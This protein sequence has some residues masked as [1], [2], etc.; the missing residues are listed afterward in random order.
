M[1]TASI[2]AKI[3]SAVDRIKSRVLLLK[4]RKEL[5]RADLA[6]SES[7]LSECDLVHRLLTN[8]TAITTIL[9]ASNSQVLALLKS[10]KVDLPGG[11]Y[12]LPLTVTPRMTC[13]SSEMVRD[14]A[15]EFGV[16][17]RKLLTGSISS[18]PD[19]ISLGATIHFDNTRFPGSMTWMLRYCPYVIV[20]NRDVWITCNMV[21]A[22]AASDRFTTSSAEVK[23]TSAKQGQ[24]LNSLVFELTNELLAF[25][26]G[27]VR[28]SYILASC[29]EK[30][31][32]EG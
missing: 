22:H 8:P 27:R 28:I 23:M 29:I 3:Q 30:L 12:V 26:Q 18:F 31:S 17:L 7:I 16:L 1:A 14:V 4:T 19:V 15:D 11:W 25:H 2:E 20:P 5:T 9:I 6:L 13:F 24:D 21:K 32:E 10:A